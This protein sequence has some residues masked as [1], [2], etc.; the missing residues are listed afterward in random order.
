MIDCRECKHHKVK[1]GKVKCCEDPAYP[2]EV[3][4]KDVRSDLPCDKYEPIVEKLPV[5]RLIENLEKSLNWTLGDTRLART[6]NKSELIAR[7][8]TWKEALEIIK[9]N[10]K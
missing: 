2:N 1:N 6:I 9:E 10:L 4:E 7:I 5:I 3:N 8:T